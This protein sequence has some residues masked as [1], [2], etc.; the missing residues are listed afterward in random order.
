MVLLVLLFLSALLVLLPQPSTG[1]A[2]TRHVPDS[3]MRTGLPLYGATQPRL[4]ASKFRTKAM[5]LNRPLIAASVAA[6]WHHFMNKFVAGAMGAAPD[7]S[8]S[9]R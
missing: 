8:A 1:R 6:V 4:C 7:V 2:P 9:N 3:V 5:H